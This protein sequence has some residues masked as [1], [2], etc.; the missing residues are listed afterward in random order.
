MIRPTLIN[1]NPNELE[2]YPFMI[3]LMLK[4]CV[5]KETKGVDNNAFNMIT[6]MNLNQ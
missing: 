4:I 3:S 2:Y 1:I 6:N 5:P